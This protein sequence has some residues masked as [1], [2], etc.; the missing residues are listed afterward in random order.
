MRCMCRFD[1]TFV[2]ELTNLRIDKLYF[3]RRHTIAHSTN[4]RPIIY[5]AQQQYWIVVCPI[6]FKQALLFIVIIISSYNYNAFVTI[7]SRQ[8]SI[9]HSYYRFNSTKHSL[10]PEHVG[11]NWKQCHQAPIWPQLEPIP[12]PPS[13]LKFRIL[14]HLEKA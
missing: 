4:N 1:A 3:Q 6:Q 7:T 12:H 13:I 2:S 9:A 8:W 10:Q 14:I 5:Y 11:G